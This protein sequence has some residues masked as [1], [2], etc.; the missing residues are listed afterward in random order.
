MAAKFTRLNH[1]IAIKLHLVAENCIICSS[2]SK[3]LVRKLLD[4]PSFI[5]YTRDK[6]GDFA[7]RILLIKI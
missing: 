7:D 4:T 6:H 2:G 5:A 1:K 3:R